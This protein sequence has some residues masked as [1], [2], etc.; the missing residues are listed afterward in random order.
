MSS[1]S[2][3]IEEFILE[4][5]GEDSSLSISRNDLADYFNCAPSQI[6]YVIN[7]RFNFERGFATESRKGGGGYIKISRLTQNKD[8]F[9]KNLY[10][11]ADTQNLTYVQAEYL[12]NT[13]AEKKYITQSEKSLILSSVAP[14]VLK[15]PIDLENKL[16]SNILKGVI[17]CLLKGDK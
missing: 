1:I 16:R 8:E 17:Q 14:K 5:I 15:T 2:R 7:T 11:I 12:L 4:T 3:V 9:L 6:N 10:E 13:L